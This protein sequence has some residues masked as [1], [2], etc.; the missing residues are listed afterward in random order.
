MLYRSIRSVLRGERPV[1]Y[2]VANRI[3]HRADLRRLYEPPYS[4]VVPR[5]ATRPHVTV[6]ET[7]ALDC[8]VR[9]L[10]ITEAA[11]HLNLAPGAVKNSLQ[12]LR[13]RHGLHSQT[14]LLRFASQQGWIAPVAAPWEIGT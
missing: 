6:G 8:L 1:L 5:H 12:R 13:V 4:V 2:R 11:K 10:T 7:M 9:G 3:A 14:Q